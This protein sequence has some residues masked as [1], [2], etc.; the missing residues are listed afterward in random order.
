MVII[1][2]MTKLGSSCYGD[3]Y[4]YVGGGSVE[5]LPRE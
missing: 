4:Y 2:V 5:A 3:C 1:A